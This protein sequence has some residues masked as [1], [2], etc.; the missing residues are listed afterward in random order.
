MSLLRTRRYQLLSLALGAAV[1]VT[2]TPLVAG[3]SSKATA[4]SVITAAQASMLKKVSVHVV[5]KSK[6]GTHLSKVVVD[7]GSKSG[8]ETISSGT[9]TVT[10]T[11]TPTYAYLSGS[12]TGLTQIMGLTSAEQTKIG[13]KAMAMK[14]G[15]SQYSNLKS[16]LTT[17][18]FASM[19]PA[20]KGSMLTTTGS[21]NSKQYVLSWTTAATSTSAKTSTVMSLSS[22]AS[23]LPVKEKITSAKGSGITTYSR[24]GEKVSPKPPTSIV[25]YTSVFG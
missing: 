15:T 12:A 21:G 24:W 25:T 10:I 6:A 20:V 8:Q 16:N 18:V 14:V 2:A 19:L 17:P 22:G 4:T 7:I 11:I 23:P 5:V 1:F 9:K 13:S 3:A